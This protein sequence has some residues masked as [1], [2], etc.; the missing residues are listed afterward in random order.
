MFTRISWAAVAAL[1]F[2]VLSLVAAMI[3]EPSLTIAF[4]F[5]AVTWAILSLKERT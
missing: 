3:E 5:G 4:G 1:V 2:L